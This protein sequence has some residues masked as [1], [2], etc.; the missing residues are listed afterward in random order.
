VAVVNRLSQII[1]GNRKCYQRPVWRKEDEV[2]VRAVAFVD[3]YYFFI[4]DKERYNFL[5][6][7]H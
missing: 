5:N 3:R 7:F 1:V 4:L 6:G 2:I